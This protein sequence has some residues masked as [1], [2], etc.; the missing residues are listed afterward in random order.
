MKNKNTFY[1]ILLLF[2]VGVVWYLLNLN[3]SVSQPVGENQNNAEV[4]KA[5][6]MP[7]F[8]LGS[9]SKTEGQNVFIQVGNQEKKIIIDEKTVIVQQIN[10][11]GAFKNIP[12]SL[13]DIKSS[14][15]IVVYYIENFDLEYKA[16]K[17][18]ILNF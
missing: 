17:I 9:V 13:S 10:D 18:Q 15:K 12:A 14:L 1:I 8:I 11:A 3:K 6:E 2:I 16:S 5:Q 7:K 4:Q